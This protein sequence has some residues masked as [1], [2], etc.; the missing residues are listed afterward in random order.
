MI[1]YYGK[2][3]PITLEKLVKPEYTALIIVDVQNILLKKGKL[4]CPDMVN[5]LKSLI[6]KGRQ[7]GILLIYIEDILLPRRMSDSA[8]W[9]RHYMIGRHT[10][11]PTI[12]RESVLDGSWEQQTINDIKPLHDDVIIKKYRSSAFVGTS[13]DLILRNNRIKTTIITGTV[14]HGCVESTC[15]SASNEYFVV[16]PED[17]IWARNVELHDA[18]LKIMKSRYDVVR[19]EDIK[20]V[21]SSFKNIL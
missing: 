9:I 15:R 16:I 2:E 8:P 5:K 10:D 1:E 4:A 20:L 14:T 3:I 18:C 7:V 12:L 17:C 11:D 13:L 6:E 21:W 19:S